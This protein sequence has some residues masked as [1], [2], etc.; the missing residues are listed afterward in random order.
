MKNMCRERPTESVSPP[1]T[2]AYDF[3]LGNYC[4]DAGGLALGLE[5]QGLKFYASGGNGAWQCKYEDGRIIWKGLPNTLVEI[6]S[7]VGDKNVETTS[8]GK[9]ADSWV[10]TFTTES[11]KR[12]C[13]DNDIPTEL[14]DIITTRRDIMVCL[15]LFKEHW[16]AHKYFIQ[17]TLSSPWDSRLW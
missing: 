17:D 9:E 6:L 14:E 8:L 10:I 4:A 3:S 12:K 2:T 15:K 11:G 7:Q 16:F 1:Y 13:F 5:P